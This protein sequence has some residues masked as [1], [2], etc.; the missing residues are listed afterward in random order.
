M[1][2]ESDADTAPPGAAT[3]RDPRTS[4]TRLLWWLLPAILLAALNLRAP[5]SVVS[6]L[7]DPIASDLQL[8]SLALSVL[9]TLPTLCLG[10]FA[11]LGPTLR[12]RVGEE[13]MIAWCTLV[14]VLGSVL[15]LQHASTALFAGTVLVVAALGM[16]NVMMPALIK[17]HFGDRYVAVT[18]VYTITMTLGAAITSAAAAPLGRAVGSSWLVPL[19]VLTVP[20]ALLACFGWLP[21]LRQGAGH[22]QLQT[23]PRKLWRDGIAWQVTVFFGALAMTSY[24]IL[25]W[26]PTI[27][28]DRGMS[29]DQSGMLL[30]V[31]ALVQAA[32]MLSLPVLIPKLGDQRLLAVG[33]SVLNGLGLAGVILA[34]VPAGVWASAVILGF[35][36]GAGFALALSVIGLRAANPAIAS[37]LSG[38]AQGIGYL[39]A[40]IGPMGAGLL[41]SATGGWGIPLILLLIVCLTQLVSGLSAGRARYALESNG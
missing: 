13:R 33:V 34:P 10:A 9:T 37:G 28:L 25:G 23:I 19:A 6:A 21:M 8:S 2:Q 16:I 27:G 36:Q 39:I 17:R 5:I 18:A 22:Q 3:T 20:L 15:R 31:S 30:S 4:R 40:V 12:Y 32:G 7:L 38:M 1:L 24:F 35:G 41:R 11:F 26:L 29:M 14:L